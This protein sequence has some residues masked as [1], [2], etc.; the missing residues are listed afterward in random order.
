MKTHYISIKQFI[1]EFLANVFVAAVIY[2]IVEF[3]IPH[4]TVVLSLAISLIVFLGIFYL[5]LYRKYAAYFKFNNAG[6]VGYYTDFPV[7]ENEAVLRSATHTVCYAGIS[8]KTI[9]P[10][11]MEVCANSAYISHVHFI[12]M[13]PES[14]ALIDQIAFLNG[15]PLT[16]KFAS[17]THEMQE[18]INAQ[19]AVER[20]VIAANLAVIKNSPLFQHKKISIHL[21]STFMPFWMYIIDNEKIYIGILEE[22]KNGAHSPVLVFSRTKFSPSP[23]D[24]FFNIWTKMLDNAGKPLA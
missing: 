23:F 18:K 24:L 20:Q 17:L 7:A 16:T 19:V 11:F 14:P 1:W 8:A 4:T 21:S 9:L 13:S 22:G 3:V 15:I 6:G 10:H 12:L 5:W 2:I